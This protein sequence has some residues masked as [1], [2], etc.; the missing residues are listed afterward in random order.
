M[1]SLI[2]VLLVAP[3][4]GIDNGL[5]LTPPMGWRSWM[6]FKSYPNQHE[7]GKIFAG[8]VSRNRSVDGTPTS[9]LDLGYS[10]V[11]LD[12]GWQNCSGDKFVYHD[13]DGNPMVRKDRFPNMTNLTA[14]AHSLGLTMGWYG[15][16]CMRPEKEAP[17]KMYEG[18][19]AATVRYGW[20]GIKLDGCGAEYDLD[21][22][23]KLFNATGKPIMIE[24]CHWGK[25]VPNETWCPWNY[26]RTCGDMSVGYGNA[27]ENVLTTKQW[28]ERGLSRPGCWAYPDNMVFGITPGNGLALTLAEGR[29]HFGMWCITSSPLILSLDVSNATLMDEYWP[30]ISNTF[31]IAVNQAWSGYSGSPYNQSNETVDITRWQRNIPAWQHFYKPVAVGC[32]AVML[33][34]H[35]NVTHSNALYFEDVP[36]LNCNQ[37]HGCW[38]IDVWSRRSMGPMAGKFE[39][40]IDGHDSVFLTLGSSSTS[41]PAPFAG[42]GVRIV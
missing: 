28:A 33:V 16:N 35:D 4:A 19:V 36:D 26:Y 18:D 1:L 10:D 15:N 8:M 29:T 30:V 42:G 38:V 5:A 12:N 41:C 40:D 14:T 21:L 2:A 25:T 3:V 24:N 23:A 9:L 13:N 39:A 20:D 6:L 37:Q 22:F 31:A 32:V 11:G 17:R 34:N 27:V 7:F